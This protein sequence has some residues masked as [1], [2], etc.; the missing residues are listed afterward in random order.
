[1]SLLYFKY[2]DQCLSS[3]VSV[4]PECVTKFNELKL[5][6][7]IKW[8]IYKLSDDQREIVVEEASSTADYEAFRKKL[9]DAKSKTKS[10][11]ESIGPRYAVFDFEYSTEEGSR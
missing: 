4:N 11:A 9:L 8:I 2:A 6:K 1:M 10:G 3:S 7:Q 5:G